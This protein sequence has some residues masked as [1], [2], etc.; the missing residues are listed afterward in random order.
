MFQHSLF[1]RPKVHGHF[2]S[3]RIIPFSQFSVQLQEPRKTVG[4]LETGTSFGS[5][6]SGFPRDVF[7]RKAL[8]QRIACG[9][10]EAGVG[11][12][13]YEPGEQPMSVDR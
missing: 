12:S 13:S 1:Q 10:D 5:E 7:C 3:L 6:V 11:K 8:A 2:L 9:L 4:A